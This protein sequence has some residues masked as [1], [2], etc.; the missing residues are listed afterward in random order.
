MVFNFFLQAWAKLEFILVCAWCFHQIWQSMSQR[1]YKEMNLHK[2]VW[3]NPVFRSV[4]LR[5]NEW[6]CLLKFLQSLSQRFAAHLQAWTSFWCLKLFLLGLSVF[7]QVKEI[8]KE[9]PQDEINFCLW[10]PTIFQPL[11]DHF[12]VCNLPGSLYFKETIQMQKPE[13]QK[14][15]VKVFSGPMNLL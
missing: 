2:G 10:K 4:I 6:S 8:E 3:T 7:K 13:L 9:G 11:W 14:G 15:E 5:Q 1:V 12:T